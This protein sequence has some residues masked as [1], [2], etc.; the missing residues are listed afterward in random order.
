MKFFNQ[1]QSSIVFRFL[2]LTPETSNS[3]CSVAHQWL[4]IGVSMMSVPLYTSTIK[5][6]HE[7]PSFHQVYGNEIHLKPKFLGD[8]GISLAL[9]LS[10]R[11]IKTRPL[12]ANTKTEIPQVTDACHTHS[13]SRSNNLH[14]FYQTKNGNKNGKKVCGKKGEQPKSKQKFFRWCGGQE[15][16]QV[17]ARP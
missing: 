12:R 17:F 1:K 7:S 9:Q 2:T 11:P 6:M 15:R 14:I 16:M 3:S 8:F 4:F 10:L 5:L 13:H